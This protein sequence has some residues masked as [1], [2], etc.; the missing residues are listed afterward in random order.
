VRKK[1]DLE[2]GI[3]LHICSFKKSDRTF[4]KCDKKCDRTVALFRRK[5]QSHNGTLEKS[6]KKCDRT[7]ALLR[8]ASKSAIA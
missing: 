8:R 6:D 3:F 1:C 2:I 4:E 7:I 5:A